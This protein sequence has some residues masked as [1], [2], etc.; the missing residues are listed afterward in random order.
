[1]LHNRNRNTD[2]ELVLSRAYLMSSFD[3]ARRTGCTKD[4]GS[5]YIS[6]VRK[7]SKESY[8]RRIVKCRLLHFRPVAAL[9]ELEI[10]NK[11]RRKRKKAKEQR[12]KRI[13]TLLEMP[14]DLMEN[15]SVFDVFP[16]HQ[17]T[18]HRHSLDSSAG[19]KARGSGIFAYS[20]GLG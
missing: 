10:R 15:F 13:T 4:G 18:G 8:F 6:Q 11:R 9:L 20:K 2:I 1:M 12:I 5:Q 7:A 14:L 3:S 17:G 19:T 16:A